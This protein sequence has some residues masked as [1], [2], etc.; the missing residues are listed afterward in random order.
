MYSKTAINNSIYQSLAKD[1]ACN[2]N[3]IF[4]KIIRCKFYFITFNRISRNF[5][6][7]NV[8]DS[9]NEN[10]QNADFII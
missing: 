2:I 6:N 3:V 4:L 5:A 9:I 7:K 1:L 8:S 10:S